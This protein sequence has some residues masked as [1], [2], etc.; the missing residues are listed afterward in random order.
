MG[1]LLRQGRPFGE[2][3]DALVSVLDEH[4]SGELSKVLGAV[5]NERASL[6]HDTQFA[7]PALFA[8]H[9]ASARAWQERGIEPSFVMGHS[10]GEI[11]AAHVAGVL[12]VECAARLVTARGQLMQACRSDGAM[13]SL[14][15]TADE[16]AEAIIDYGGRL[17]LAGINGERQIVISGDRDALDEVVATVSGQGRRARRL[18][19]SHAFHSHH[20]DEMLEEYAKVAASCDFH[21]PAITMVSTVTGQPMTSSLEPGEGLRDPAYWVRQIR[22]PVRFADAVSTLI[23]LGAMTT[24]ECGPEPVLSASVVGAAGHRGIAIQAVAPDRRLAS[25]ERAA[26]LAALGTAYA[27]TT[28]IDLASATNPS[29]RPVNLPTYP[30]QR[31]RL[32]I[33]PVAGDRSACITSATSHPWLRQVIPVAD[34]DRIMVTGQISTQETHWLGDHQVFGATVLPGAAL[35]EVAVVAAELAGTGGLRSLRLHHP[36]VLSDGPV[37]LQAVVTCGTDH[38][39]DLWARPAGLKGDEPWSL[40]ASGQTGAMVD[41]PDRV[42]QSVG[43][44][45]DP[46]HLRDVLDRRG[47]HYGDA[48][49][50]LES[51]KGGDGLAC[52][53]IRL[54]ESLRR[55][56]GATGFHLH[57]AIVDAALHVFGGL[58]GPDGLSQADTYIA[59]DLDASVEI[60]VAFNN[61]QIRCLPG[62]VIDVRAQRKDAGIQVELIGADDE[63]LA[64]M[65]V[66]TQPIR[67]DEVELHDADDDTLMRID[68]IPIEVRPGATE[69]NPIVVDFTDFD[70]SLEERLAGALVNLQNLASHDDDREV[71]VLTKGCVSVDAGDRLR[72]PAGAALWG[73]VRAWR[74]EVPARTVRLLD[75][76]DCARCSDLDMLIGMVAGSAETELAIRAGRLLGPRLR[77][78]GDDLLVP[79]DDTSWQI[80]PTGE[81]RLDRLAVVPLQQTDLGPH[82]VCIEVHACGVNFRD[83]LNLLDVVEAPGL[84]LECVGVVL[85]TGKEIDHVSVGDRVMGL[86]AGSMATEAVTD[87]RYV[88]RVPDCLTD[89]E[90]ATIPLAYLTAYHGLVNLAGVCP[91]KRVLVHAGAGGVGMAAIALARHLGAEVLATA[92]PHKW[93]ALESLGLG[94]EQLA[95]S[96]DPGFAAAWEPVDVVL[97]SLT[98]AMIDESLSL[99]RE[100]GLFL[101]IGKTDVRDAH[102]VARRHP[103]VSYLPFD[104]MDNDPEQIL[105]MLRTV[106]RMVEEGHVAPLPFVADHIARASEVLRVM[107]AGSHVGKLVLTMPRQFDPAGTV[108]ITGGS[109]DLAGDIARRLVSD[110]GARHLVLA[111]RSGPQGDP[112]GV[113]MARLYAAG[114]QTVKLVSCDIGDRDDVRRLVRDFERPLTAIFHLAGVVDDGILQNQ[115]ATRAAAVIRPKAVG[116]WLLHEETI[117]ERLAAFVT[118]SSVAGTLGSAGQ[119]TYAAANAALDA[120]MRHRVQTGQPGLSLALGP[121]DQT[122]EGMMGRLPVI[123]ERMAAGGLLPLSHGDLASALSRALRSGHAGLVVARTDRFRLD[124]AVSPLL[125]QIVR[126]TR[127]RTGHEQ[128]PSEAASVELVGVV[129]EKRYGFLLDLVRSEVAIVLGLGAA[130]DVSPTTSMRSVGLDSLMAVELRNRLCARTGLN[131]PMTVAFDAPTP[132]EMARLMNDEIG[133]GCTSTPDETSP[134]DDR[135]LTD[136]EIELVLSGALIEQASTISNRAS[137]IPPKER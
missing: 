81:G 101:E 107:S 53:R 106:V 23:E 50:G 109:G 130:S 75:L 131:L 132:E 19:V 31:K 20:M 44:P 61:I 9:V 91:G 121:V 115:D 77:C 66:V 88:V 86:A 6:I 80:V 52:G 69:T 117:H 41:V 13:A 59:E 26:D 133:F 85:A 55:T 129:P 82:Q 58:D 89:H 108:L 72:D 64:A 3:F 136:Q 97:N 47:I 34:E 114:A 71:L 90:A 67:P 122:C 118:Y 78:L 43:N 12:G 127:C 56:H 135:D 125:T 2:I 137:R 104:L 33:D 48:F 105:R 74:Q 4:M 37:D 21:A 24:I 42:P 28:N 54:P 46:V 18:T 27:L 98:G 29:A 96:R 45:I 92:S 5:D 60:P 39:I 102:E 65:T 84:G 22:E 123:R 116:A 111:S 70:G 51:L 57:P 73:L 10:I 103:G 119:S 124:P 14:E 100:G 79:D 63:L 99:L 134:I 83:A 32:W 25:D 68:W 40:Y 113:L 126:P 120:L 7:Q 36:L 16:A 87:A 110:Y 128:V 76:D 1:S 17:C 62:E 95:T 94:P 8:F 38:S 35:L 30:F 93:P 49:T 112:D 11:A 15:L